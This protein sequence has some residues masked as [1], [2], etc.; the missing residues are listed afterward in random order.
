MEHSNSLSLLVSLLFII[1]LLEIWLHK[2]EV[3]EMK[4]FEVDSMLVT[5]CGF[6][7]G[8]CGEQNEY[9]L[10]IYSLIIPIIPFP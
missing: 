4:S 5:E 9:V 2:P 8:I 10:S 7:L 1:W 6:G 3:P